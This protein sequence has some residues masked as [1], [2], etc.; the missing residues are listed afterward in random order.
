M[1]HEIRRRHESGQDEGDR[2]LKQAST[3]SQDVADDGNES[4]KT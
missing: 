4:R 2:P 3:I 1:R